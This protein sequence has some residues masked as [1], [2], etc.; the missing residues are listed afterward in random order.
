MSN[1]LVQLQAHYHHCGVAASESACQL[2]RSLGGAV[3]AHDSGQAVPKASCSVERG[4][5]RLII[6]MQP[7][8]AALPSERGCPLDELRS[9]TMS[10]VC[11]IH[12]WIE[13][14]RVLPTIRREVYK[15]DESI[16][17]EGRYNAEAASENG[18]KLT[19]RVIIPG[20][21]EEVV[22]RRIIEW[23][24]DSIFNHLHPP[25]ALVQLQGHYNHRGEAAS[26]KCLSAATFVRRRLGRRCIHIRTLSVK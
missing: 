14:K 17:H 23:R 19:R 16:R 15:S 11:D 1:A 4:E 26:E 12:G 10:P 22:Q 25:N 24:I 18:G 3:E 21:R 5:R 6:N 9:N 13:Q 20:A 7:L 8:A 2:Q